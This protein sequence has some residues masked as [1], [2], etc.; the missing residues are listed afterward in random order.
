MNIIIMEESA[1]IMSD[2]DGKPMLFDYPHT[3]RHYLEKKAGSDLSGTY[4]IASIE[5]RV[6]VEMT[7]TVSERGYPDRLFGIEEVEEAA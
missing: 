2:P 4:L 5:K 3:A 6:T 1:E 7:P